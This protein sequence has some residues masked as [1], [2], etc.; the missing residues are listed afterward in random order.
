MKANNTSHSHAVL[1]ILLSCLALPPPACPPPNHVSQ[2]NQL[3]KIPASG[4]FSPF[5]FTL[6]TFFF[7]ANQKKRQLP[8]N[9]PG[10]LS[11]GA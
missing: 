3:T 7:T 8:A 11:K 10:S 9:D 4:L 6:S 1:V 5:A 2:T